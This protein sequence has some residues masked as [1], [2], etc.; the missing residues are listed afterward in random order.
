MSE[1]KIPEREE[2]EPAAAPEAVQSSD[3]Q[4]FMELVNEGTCLIP[5]PFDGGNVSYTSVN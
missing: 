2:K 1:K 3:V 4:D 5:I